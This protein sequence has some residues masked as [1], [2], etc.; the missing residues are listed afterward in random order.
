[1][2]AVRGDGV[3]L[4]EWNEKYYLFDKEKDTFLHWNSNLKS[5]TIKNQA[6]KIN[7]QKSASVLLK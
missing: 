3:V 1:L 6:S 7:I 4:I 5:L 2:E